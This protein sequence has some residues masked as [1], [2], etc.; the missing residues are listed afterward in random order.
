MVDYYLALCA[1]AGCR[2][3]KTGRH[4][5]LPAPPEALA[6]ADAYFRRLGAAPEER[7]LGLSVGTSFGSSKLWTVEG[8]AAVA[9]HFLG[10]GLRVVLFGGPGDRGV[11]ERVLAACGRKGAAAATDIPLADLCA[12]MKRC[13]ALVSTDSGGRHIGLAAGIPVVVVMGPTHPNYS[14]VDSDRFAVLLEKVE[15]WPCHLKE[16]PIDHRCMTRIRPEAVIAATEDFLAG[17]R[18]L[19]G[20]RPWITRPGEEDARWALA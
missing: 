6:R 4:L 20:A 15:C 3:E 9:D 10:R 18:P 14:E 12:H 17:R 8:W 2:V 19:G 5:E 16:C 1:L 7:I 13:A 11:I